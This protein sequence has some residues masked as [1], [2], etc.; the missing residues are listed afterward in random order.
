M[1]DQRYNQLEKEAK[2]LKYW[3]DNDIYKFERDNREIYSIDTPPPTVSGNIH[4]GHIFSYSQTEMMARFKRLRGYN[5]F[6]P[7]GFDDNGLA[8][9]RFVEK[10]HNVKPQEIGREK[11]RKLCYET[12]DKYEEEFKEL[13]SK[14]GVSTD[15]NIVYKLIED[16]FSSFDVVIYKL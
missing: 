16:C 13:F 7:F 1:L 9:E 4:I 10:E 15:W 8:S 14:M 5:V 11:F 12:T 3:E 2:W 6:Y